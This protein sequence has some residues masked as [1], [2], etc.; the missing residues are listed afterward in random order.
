MKRISGKAKRFIQ[1]RKGF[2][3]KRLRGLCY[4][5]LALSFLIPLNAAYLYHSYYE[6]I[7][8]LGRKHFAD[9]DEE[10]LLAF[11][12]KTPRVL[13]SP[14]LSHQHDVISLLQVFFFQAYSPI[15]HDSRTPVLRC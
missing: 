1:R 15:L 12:N 14:G 6:D 9:G 7:D 4:F 8:L 11:I 13:Y 2:A 5:M 3:M 10:N